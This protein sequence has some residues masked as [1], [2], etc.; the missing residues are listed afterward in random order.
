MRKLI[1]KIF[2]FDEEYKKIYEEKINNSN[3]AVNSIVENAEKASEEDKKSGELKTM[4]KVTDSLNM[5]YFASE[6]SENDPDEIKMWKESVRDIYDFSVKNL[7]LVD[8]TPT[9]GEGFDEKN[10][11]ITNYVTTGNFESGKVAK[12][13]KVGFEFND[14]TIST[15]EIE[16]EK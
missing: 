16:V 9:I 7:G 13:K 2:K 1:K 14:E 8:I 10:S 15:P 12:I 4:K 11:K 5:V 3:D 6:P